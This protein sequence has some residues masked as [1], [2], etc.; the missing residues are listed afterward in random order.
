M[1]LEEDPAV[2]PW[3]HALD[4]RYLGPAALA[5]AARA[6]A[7]AAPDARPALLDLL[8]DEHALWRCHSAWACTAVCPADV[9]PAEA[10]M[11]LRRAVIGEKLRQLFRR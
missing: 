7:S 2:A 6:L 4:A 10:I 3:L 1:H 5:G 8:D 11:G 9:Q